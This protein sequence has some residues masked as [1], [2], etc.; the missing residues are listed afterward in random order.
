MSIALLLHLSAVIVW[1][2]GMFFAHA[3]LR[4]AA[5]A[6]LD[7]PQRLPLLAATL[8]QFFRW[9]TLAIVVLLGTGGY[10]IMAMGGMR[11]VGTYVHAMIGLGVLMMLIFGHVRFASYRRLQA[12]VA[13]KAWPEA[14]AAMGS[15]RKFL[16]VN[17]VL[18]AITVVIG[19]L[20]RGL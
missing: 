15:V 14:G 7:A 3:A 20:G 10:L 9:V 16:M 13:A 4:P 8:R 12:A 5:M 18:G 11:A 6:T 17:L 19:V 1:V 2:G